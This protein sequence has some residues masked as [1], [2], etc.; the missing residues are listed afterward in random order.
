MPDFGVNMID[1]GAAGLLVNLV[2]VFQLPGRLRVPMNNMGDDI[3]RGPIFDIAGLKQLVFRQALKV[4]F[5]LS[6]AYLQ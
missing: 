2:R 6:V 1:A 5:L 4:G 3:F